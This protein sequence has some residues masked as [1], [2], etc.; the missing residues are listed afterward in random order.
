MYYTLNETVA[1]KR[2]FLKT[3][4]IILGA[5]IGLSLGLYVAARTLPMSPQ[6]QYYY[7][8]GKP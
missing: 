3:F 4:Y 1:P 8:Q 2:Y 6:V 7:V 5:V